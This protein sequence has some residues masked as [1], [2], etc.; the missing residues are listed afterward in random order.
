MGVKRVILVLAFL[1]SNLLIAQQP[2][3]KFSVTGAV[4]DVVT[5][6][7]LPNVSVF[8]L[9]KIT[10]KELT[11]GTSDDKG[12][13]SIENIPESKVRLRLSCVGYQTQVLDSLALDNSSRVGLIQ[14][15]PTAIEMPEL[16]IKTIKP[17]IE[18]HADKQVINI[19]RLPGNNGTV[20]E[21]L[22]N[23]GLVEVEP[24]TNKITVRGQSLKIQMDGHEYNMPQEMLAQLPAS[25]LDQVEL[26]L[27]PGAKESAEGGMYILNL[28]TK[29]SAFS[30]LSGMVNLNMLTNNNTNGGLY[31]GYKANKLNLFGQA[32]G[33]YSEMNN[34][35]ESERYMYTSPAMYFQKSFS[36]GKNK[37]FYGYFKVGFD[38]DFDESNTSTFYVNYNGF[39]SKNN[40]SGNTTVINSNNIYQY[41]YSN[42]YDSKYNNSNISFYGF[43]KKKFTTRGN[44]LIFDAMYSILENPSATDMT[45]GYSTKPSKPQLQNSDNEVSARTFILKTDY[46]LPIGLNKF[47]TGYHLTYRT[48]NNDYTVE[49]FSYTYNLW[50]DSLSLSNQF[51][52]NELINALYASYAHKLGSFDIKVGVRAENLSTEG[53]QVTQ[54][55][56]FKENFLS[57]FPNLNLSYKLS[58]MFQLTFTAARR[59][60]Y[61]QIFYINP[62]RQYRSPNVFSAGNPKLEPSYANSYS[63]NLSQYL[64]LYYNKTTGGVTYATTTENDSILLSSYINLSSQDTYGFQLTLPYYN[65][66]MTPFKLPDFISSFYISLNYRYS[67]QNG[68]F[69]GEDLSLNEKSLSLNGYISIKLWEG[70]EFSMS[71]MYRP[72]TET[73]RSIMGENK[74]LYFYLSKS[75]MENKLRVYAN[76][77]DPFEWQ[78]GYNSSIGDNYRT[79]SQYRSLNSR[80]IGIGITYTFNEYKDRRDRNLDDGRDSGD[81]GF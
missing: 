43:Y 16:V 11:G 42:A 67:K 66:P 71:G 61:P 37:F 6:K 75:F 12:F 64:S 49:N 13:F 53:N 56:I 35:S 19:D 73:R 30:N 69:I 27:A 48:R 76:I 79:N 32:Y 9:S 52:Y 38:Y 39:G 54:N 15:F 2:A 81:R 33:S 26:I 41:D 63:L 44:E 14:L 34:R 5:N 28:L 74:F 80:S 20:T 68:S 47:E 10:G 22:R 24:S 45:L 50:I 40:N 17:M 59:V 7:P 70:I 57:F 62:F 3:E 78:R 77:A 58:D 8:V 65:S 25:M 18:V 72:K 55:I 29:K 46:A 51:K 21:A 23:T 36:D 4:S 31:F 1:F 60:T